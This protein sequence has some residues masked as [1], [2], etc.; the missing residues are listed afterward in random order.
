[1]AMISSVCMDTATSG[2]LVL[3]SN[4]RLICSKRAYN[5]SGLLF[6]LPTLTPNFYH[7]VVE[8]SIDFFRESMPT[9]YH[10]FI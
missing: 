5:V 7:D 8:A 9:A 2:S 3:V 4:S 10:I 1:M 6:I